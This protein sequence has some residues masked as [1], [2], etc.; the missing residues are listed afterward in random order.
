MFNIKLSNMLLGEKLRKLREDAGQPQRRAAAALDIDTGTYCKIEKGRF[1][2]NKGQIIML[3]DFYNCDKNEL[4]KLLLAD[5]LI[6]V[7]KDEDL[8]GEAFVLAQDMLNIKK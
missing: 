4:I 5:K 8:A 7:V 3:S 6:D 2:P 1:L